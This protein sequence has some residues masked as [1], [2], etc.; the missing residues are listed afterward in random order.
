MMEP[1]E[2]RQLQQRFTQTILS[3]S[4]KLGAQ[5]REG[6][7][8]HSYKMNHL[9]FHI[10]GALQKS[11]LQDQFILTLLHSTDHT[12][13][14]HAYKGIPRR[15]LEPLLDEYAATGQHWLFGLCSLSMLRFKLFEFSANEKDEMLRTLDEQHLPHIKDGTSTSTEQALLFE[16]QLLSFQQHVMSTSGA[17]SHYQTQRYI[18]MGQLADIDFSSGSYHFYSL[19][20]QAL[21]LAKKGSQLTSQSAP[22]S[23]GGLP[24]MDSVR[25]AAYYYIKSSEAFLTV[26]A[27]HAPADQQNSLLLYKLTRAFENFVIW[28][29]AW[30]IYEPHVH[31]QQHKMF[32]LD[33]VNITR[34]AEQY[35]VEK[36]HKEF[37]K[38]YKTNM[39]VCYCCSP[40]LAGMRNMDFCVC[41]LAYDKWSSEMATNIEDERED[42]QYFCVRN[43]IGAAFYLRRERAYQVCTQTAELACCS[44][45]NAFCSSS[46]YINKHSFWTAADGKYACFG[47]EESLLFFRLM[48]FLI[49]PERA[50]QAEAEDYFLS[51]H[52]NGCTLNDW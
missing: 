47:Y 6:A 4:E 33:G 50:E 14:S 1:E 3:E 26:P 37:R 34:L 11:L 23:A 51:N 39:W 15:M 41:D 22:P 27:T 48:F 24:S 18:V 52:A 16:A 10:K 12:V 2:L 44:S 25:A 35:D 13:A 46:V 43:N 28:T 7:A 36:S 8:V 5:S 38:T 31:N 32:G 42:F 40:V 20:D 9:Y 21:I 30:E 29:A 17:T 45:W 49:C 19:V